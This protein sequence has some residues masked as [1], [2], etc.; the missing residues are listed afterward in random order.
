MLDMRM[1]SHLVWSLNLGIAFEST[2]AEGGMDID[3]SAY[4]HFKQ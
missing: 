1:P 3:S 2:A 4:S